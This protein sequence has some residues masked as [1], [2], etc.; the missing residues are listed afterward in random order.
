MRADIAAGSHFARSRSRAGE[1]LGLS[2]RGSGRGLSA[3]VGP[4]G[5]FQSPKAPSGSLAA[6]PSSHCCL[7]AQPA[8]VPIETSSDAFPSRLRRS[9]D[10]GL[11]PDT[12]RKVG[13]ACASRFFLFPPV[14]PASACFDPC[15]SPPLQRWSPTRQIVR[16]LPI[17]PQLASDQA[18]QVFRF[19]QR[20]FCAILPVDNGDI[21]DKGEAAPR[22]VRRDFAL[23]P[24][25]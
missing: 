11:P 13:S 23:Q 22:P 9:E 2:G 5:S 16:C 12:S 21:V 7:S 1:G 3:P 18:G 24:R 14:P 25:F 8:W 6:C 20:G 15:G 19:A 17:I 4:L 10:P